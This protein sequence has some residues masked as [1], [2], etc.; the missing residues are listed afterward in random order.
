VQNRSAFR[1]KKPDMGFEE[2]RL[3]AALRAV[4]LQ[5]SAWGGR[6]GRWNLLARQEWDGVGAE[7][8]ADP[9]ALAQ[10]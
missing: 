10:A 1:K 2:A 4:A 8:E 5:H 9:P 3:R 7:Q 6:K